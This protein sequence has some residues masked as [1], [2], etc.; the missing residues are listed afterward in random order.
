MRKIKYSA[1]RNQIKVEKNKFGKFNLKNDVIHDALKVICDRNLKK[2]RRYWAFSAISANSAILVRPLHT[3]HVKS[4]SKI[5]PTC[6][7]ELW[8]QRPKESCDLIG[9]YTLTLVDKI[10]DIHVFFREIFL[11]VFYYRP[12]ITYLRVS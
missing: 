7:L 9:Q 4:I 5:I 12:V 6:P 1:E 11:I 10:F 2:I 8:R 3:I